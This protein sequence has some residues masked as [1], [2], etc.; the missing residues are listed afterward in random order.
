MKVLGVDPGY[1]NLGLTVVDLKSMTILHSENMTVRH[2]DNRPMGCVV[3]YIIVGIRKR[4]AFPSRFPYIFEAG[5]G[6]VQW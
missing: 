3:Y 5:C 1:R 4:Y 2:S 6:K